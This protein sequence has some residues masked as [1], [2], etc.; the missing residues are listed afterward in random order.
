MLA[1]CAQRES[2][3]RKNVL[4]DVAEVLDLGLQAPV[5][6]VLLEEFVLVEEAVLC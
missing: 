1:R 4:G 5:P 6:L 3:Q 2:E